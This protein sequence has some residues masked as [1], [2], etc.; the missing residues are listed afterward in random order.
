[1]I[2]AASKLG[3]DDMRFLIETIKSNPPITALDMIYYQMEKLGYLDEA[4]SLYGAIAQKTVDDG[5]WYCHALVQKDLVEQAVRCISNTKADWLDQAVGDVLSTNNEHLETRK[6]VIERLFSIV[7]T[8]F[9]GALRPREIGYS[10]QLPS[11][12]NQ[13]HARLL[14]TNLTPFACQI[15]TT[16]VA[17]RDIDQAVAAKADAA[18][19]LKAVSAENVNITTWSRGVF[20]ASLKLPN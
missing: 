14:C 6:N 1:M 4:I 2:N 7:P 19:L 13:D 9:V 5:L 18:T 3:G 20:A 12:F 11:Y 15:I 17:V 16:V 8:G 10:H